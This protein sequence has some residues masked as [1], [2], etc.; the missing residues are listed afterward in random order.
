MSAYLCLRALDEVEDHP[1][2]DNG[3]KATLLR[4][5]SRILQTNFAADDFTSALNPC[6]PELSAVTLRIS[7]WVLLAPS[8]IAPRIWEATATMADRMAQWA[9]INWLI[10]TE[11]DLDRYTFGVAGSVGLLLSDL[12]AWYNG[13]P[14]NRMHAVG[15]GRGLQAVNILRNHGED[16]ARGVEFFPTGWQ[17]EEMQAYARR[18]LALADAYTSALPVGPILDFCS[19]PLALAYATLEALVRG[20]GKL[21]RDDVLQIVNK[22]APGGA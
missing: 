7:D 19:I 11:T 13:T 4:S 21:S 5:I 2:L 3:T 9:E 6:R 1:R 17:A 8:A 20:D 18:N 22:H 12:W 16:V 10:Q 14:T 15:F